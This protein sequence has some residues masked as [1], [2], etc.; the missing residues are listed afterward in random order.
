MPTE[1]SLDSRNKRM[2]NRE[3]QSKTHFIFVW[4]VCHNAEAVLLRKT[5]KKEEKATFLTFIF[6]S[7]ETPTGRRPFF[8]FDL[9][10]IF[11]Y[12]FFATKALVPRSE[13]VAG[14][15]PGLTHATSLASSDWTQVCVRVTCGLATNWQEGEKCWKWTDAQKRDE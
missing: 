2:L 13:K 9:D 6:V 14:L 3:Q 7:I 15:I 1:C 11:F 10:H 5:E 12:F 8:F 4:L